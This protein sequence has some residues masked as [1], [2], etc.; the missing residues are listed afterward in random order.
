MDKYFR[1]SDGKIV[2]IL[3]YSVIQ[4]QKNPNTRI[5]IGCDSQVFGPEI[6]YVLCIVYRSENRGG[7]YIYKTIKKNR[8]P[9][10]VPENIQVEQ[11]LSEEVYMTMELATYIKMNSSIELECVEFDFN[12]EESHLSN[13]LIGMSTG[14]ARGMGFKTRIKPEELI[15]CKAADHIC[16]N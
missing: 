12:E 4:L 7:H 1:T 9:R 15:A 16:R 11:R 10:S 13:K 8:P 14:W 6:K 5:F 2:D 3:D